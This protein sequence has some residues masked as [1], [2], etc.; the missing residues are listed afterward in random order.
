MQLKRNEKSAWFIEDGGGGGPAVC[1]NI[2]CCRIIQ[3]R[4]ETFNTEKIVKK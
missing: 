3:M 2:L 1:R 4:S